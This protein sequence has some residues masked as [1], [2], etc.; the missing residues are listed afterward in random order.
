[1][2]HVGQR[3]PNLSGGGAVDEMSLPR[4]PTR[5]DDTGLHALVISTVILIMWA[6]HSLAFD[7]TSASSNSV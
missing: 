3:P 5:R 4:A 6:V 2:R 1:M 7:I